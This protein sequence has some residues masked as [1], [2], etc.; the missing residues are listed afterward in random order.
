MCKEKCDLLY[1]IIMEKK[2]W[3]NGHKTDKTIH[4][5]S[6]WE[7]KEKNT[8]GVSADLVCFTFGSVSDFGYDRKSR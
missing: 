5:D 6:W 7:K 1:Y 3:W 8:I 2:W 4:Y